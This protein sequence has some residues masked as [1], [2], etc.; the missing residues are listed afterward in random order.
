LLN[1][2]P[3]ATEKFIQYARGMNKSLLEEYSDETYNIIKGQFR[4]S[5]DKNKQVLVAPISSKAEMLKAGFVLQKTIKKSIGDIQK[6]DYGIYVMYN[7]ALDKRV[8]GAMGIADLHT[9][10]TTLY[11]LVSQEL[12]RDASREAVQKEFKK[13]K[14]QADRA[15][16]SIHRGRMTMFP[17]YN[18]NGYIVNYRYTFSHADKRKY[19]GVET[20]GTVNMSRTYSGKSV[21]LYLFLKCSINFSSERLDSFSIISI[22][23]SKSLSSQSKLS[24]SK[25]PNAPYSLVCQ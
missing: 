2:A 4:E 16:R 12:G 7:G 5:N 9:E 10:G 20:R 23:L 19:K 21:V 25:Y 18:K 13:R 6:G 1:K 14:K 17:I 22:T 15:F 8:N 11:Q 3:N 24:F